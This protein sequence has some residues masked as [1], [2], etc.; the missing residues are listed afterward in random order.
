MTFPGRFQHCFRHG[1]QLRSRPSSAIISRRWRKVGICL[2]RQGSGDPELENG[3][4]VGGD[5]S[6]RHLGP[7][8]G[9]T[10]TPSLRETATEEQRGMCASYVY[11]DPE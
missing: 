3:N 8:D 6:G 10:E 9:L 5:V 2:Q 11:Q 1:E 7:G 4:T